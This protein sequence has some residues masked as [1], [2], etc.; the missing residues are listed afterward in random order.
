M[1][2]MRRWW[3]EGVQVLWTL[4]GLHSGKHKKCVCSGGFLW[5]AR[6]W[7]MRF[8]ESPDPEG[9]FIWVIS[10]FTSPPWKMLRPQACFHSSS[11]TYDS[12]PETLIITPK[13]C[14]VQKNI[15][16]CLNL[17]A[18]GVYSMQTGL[19]V[20]SSNAKIKTQKLSQGEKCSS[21]ELP[22]ELS[23]K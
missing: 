11:G 16:H 14:Y 15:C 17:L 12:S 7:L 19:M 20:C 8:R 2:H 4:S 6:E 5:G 21:P 10:E 13:V 1:A 18:G 9:F 22:T 23:A 3:S